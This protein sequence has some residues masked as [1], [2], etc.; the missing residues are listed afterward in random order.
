MSLSPPFRGRDLIHYKTNRRIRFILLIAGVCLFS[1][2][3]KTFL[4][5]KD[6]YNT[7]LLDF[8]S[9]LRAFLPF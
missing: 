8:L 5:S 4:N 3:K 2:P 1:V 6:G 9:K 7:V